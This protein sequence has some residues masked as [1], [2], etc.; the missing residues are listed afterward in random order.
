MDADCAA[1]RAADART[2]KPCGP[3]PSTLGSSLRAIRKRRRLTSPILRGDH[4]AA[5][6]TIAQGVPDVSALPVVTMLVCFFTLHA[7]LRVRPAPGIS[8]ALRFLRDIDDASPGRERAAGMNKRV[9]LSRIDF[10]IDPPR[11]SIVRCTL[12]GD[13]SGAK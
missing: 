1:R 5:V 8:C 6:P 2:V 10:W 7:R 11:C 12:R 3:V 9:L 13:R 4:G